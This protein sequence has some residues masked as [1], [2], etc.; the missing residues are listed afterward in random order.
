MK[1]IS[2]TNARAHLAHTMQQVCDDHTPIMVTRSRAEPV[3]VISLSDFEALQET[4]YLTK[5]PANATRLA[6][7]IDEIETI[8]ARDT[9]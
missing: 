9:D 8:I 4:C 5:S 7:A 6:E 1:S 2:Y 3:V